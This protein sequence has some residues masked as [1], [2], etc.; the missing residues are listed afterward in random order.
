MRRYRVILP[1]VFACLR[2]EPLPTLRKWLLAKCEVWDLIDE[3]TTEV[4]AEI[5]NVWVPL[6]RSVE[7]LEIALEALKADDEDIR[8]ARVCAI[9]AGALQE[10]DIEVMR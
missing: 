2:A 7:A 1:D 8:L 5:V 9:Y 6:F 3:S 4:D 10:M